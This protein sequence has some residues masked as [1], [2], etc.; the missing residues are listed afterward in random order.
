MFPDQLQWHVLTTRVHQKPMWTLANFSSWQARSTS[1]PAVSIH[2]INI[3]RNLMKL[4][5]KTLTFC[6]RSWSFKFIRPRFP[7]MALYVAYFPWHS[8]SF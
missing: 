8:S 4:A 3:Q 5:L 1:Q 7:A 6:S 2:V